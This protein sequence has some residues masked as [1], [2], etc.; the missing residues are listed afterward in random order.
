MLDGTLF[1]TRLTL[2][3]GICIDSTPVLVLVTMLEIF[4]LVGYALEKAWRFISDKTFVTVEDGLR[5]RSG[6]EEV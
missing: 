4:Y 2:T 3:I 5:K 1:D 6:C